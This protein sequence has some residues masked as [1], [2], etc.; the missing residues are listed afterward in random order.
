MDLDDNP[1]QVAASGAIGQQVVVIIQDH[2]M[3]QPPAI[4]LI[5]AKQQVAQPVFQLIVEQPLMPVGG[6][7][8]EIGGIVDVEVVG[9]LLLPPLRAMESEARARSPR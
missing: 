2:P 8:D 3:L 7:G 6:G 9:E 1:R 4:I 5:D